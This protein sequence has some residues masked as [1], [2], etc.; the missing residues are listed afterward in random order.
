ML[1]RI[2]VTGAPGAGKSALVAAMG[3][4]GYEVRRE[5]GPRVIRLEERTGGNG[6]PRGDPE[7]FAR[8][9][10][11]MAIADWEEARAGV[12]IFDRGV[13]DAALAL[14]R[15]GFA[16]EAEAALETYAYEAP[17][18][19]AEPWP[20]LFGSGGDRW[21]GFAEAEAEFAEIAAALD[22]LGWPVARLPR[23]GVEAR[24]DWLESLL[25]AG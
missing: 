2:L 14:A 22:R 1:R 8:L 12:V 20:E 6:T 3:G 11:R 25:K 23:E 24:A 5:P 16:A 9:C 18:V 7:R 19:L 15:L 10:L 13:P 4:R 21:Q 17:V